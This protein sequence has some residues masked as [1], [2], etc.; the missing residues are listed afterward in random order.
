M[1]GLIRDDDVAVQESPE[2][3][4]M[5]CFVGLDVSVETTAV[6]V[7]DGAGGIV[8]EFS[9]ASDPDAL[10]ASIL[11]FEP[12]R[13]CRR[14]HVWMPRSMQVSFSAVVHV[15]GCGHVSGLFMQRRV[16]RRPSWR[17]ADQAQIN[18][19]SSWLLEPRCFS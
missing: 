11:R 2:E 8:R 4:T 1:I 6:C 18:S 17:Y 7:I 16:C 15:I 12:P 10:A 9:V 3:M 19:T 13:V 5:S 14:L